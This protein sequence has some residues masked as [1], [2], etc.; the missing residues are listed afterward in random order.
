MGIHRLKHTF[1]AGELSPL[2]VG[3]VDFERYNDGCIDLVNS[4][5]LVQGPA[6]R[7]TGFKFIM[8]LAEIGAIPTSIRLIEFI[9]NI[10]QAYVLIF[11]KTSTGHIMAVATG[12]GLVTN[13][14]GD[15]TVLDVSGIWT[16]D[17]FPVFDYAQAGDDMY[18]AQS[19]CPLRI[20]RRYAHNDWRLIEP[21][22][23]SAPTIWSSTNGYP[24]RIT[25]HQQRLAVAANTVRRQTIWL[26]RAGNFL[27]FGTSSPIL[28]SDAIT[29]T[30]DS[31]TQNRIQWIASGKSLNIGTLDNEWTVTG[32]NQTALT[33]TSIL[34][35]RQSSRG[36]ESIK[37]LLIGQTTMIIERE[38]RTIN[39]FVYDYTTDGY[40]ASDVSILAPHLTEHYSVVDWA[41][42]Q[43]PNSYIW[44]VREDGQLLGFTYQ[45]DHKVVGW[46]RH[47][48][49]GSFTAVASIPNRTQREDEVW[50]VVSRTV[51]GEDRSYLEKMYPSFHGLQASDGY[52]LDSAVEGYSEAGA[53][54]FSGLLHL[55]GREVDILA[56]GTV[57]PPVVISNTGTLTLNKAYNK[58]L[59]G[60]GYTTMI[61][62]TVADMTLKDGSTLGRSQRITYLDLNLY[63]TLGFHVY[64]KSQEGEEVSEEK[65][66]RM[67]KHSTGE[68]IPLFTGWYRVDF[69]EGFL[70]ESYYSILQ[71][72]P[73]PL[74]IRAVVDTVEVFD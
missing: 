44:C 55:R 26:S 19:S 60:L 61:T 63:Q 5:V 15:P 7:R 30:L 69:M 11:C 34:A 45:R 37:P 17:T 23:A 49:Q 2:M 51:D 4:M 13:T 72:Q 39:E 67:P 73:L 38:G 1:T 46:H 6:T 43:V 68:E 12:E 35:Q 14:A 47:I 66:F 42:Q 36:S 28:A 10:Y 40:K 31:G 50:V 24:E 52:F 27:D 62:P 8:D 33:P 70:Q 21:T 65:P 56:D 16:D 59:A 3:R 54:V 25:F 48:T 58:V 53:S 74:T 71:K 57:H 29:F 20:I 9:F 18:L 41:Y 22:I 64:R 32:G